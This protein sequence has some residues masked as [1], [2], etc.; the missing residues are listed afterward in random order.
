M[1]SA[2]IVTPGQAI[3]MIPTTSAR[4]PIPIREL[5]EDLSIVR[6]PFPYRSAGEAVGRDD[7]PFLDLA[8]RA[9]GQNI[10]DP[11]VAR[12]LVGRDLGLDVVAQFRGGHGSA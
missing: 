2:R 12:V 10:D 3:A 9:L 4:T 6:I 1:T 5:A 11:H 7:I 8:R